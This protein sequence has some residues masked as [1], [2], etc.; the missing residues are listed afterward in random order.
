M[1]SHYAVGSSPR[2]Q[3]NAGWGGRG[4]TE[5]RSPGFKEEHSLETLKNLD[6]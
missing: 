3:K 5:H 6:A 2:E 4:E 1:D